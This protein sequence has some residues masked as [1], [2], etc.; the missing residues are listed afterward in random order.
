MI[1]YSPMILALLRTG[2]QS[3]LLEQHY[4]EIENEKARRAARAAP[5]R[6]LIAL[7]PDGDE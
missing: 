7:T 2:Y 3:A 1:G 6:R 5:W 4:A